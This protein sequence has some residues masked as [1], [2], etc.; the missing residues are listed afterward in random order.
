MQAPPISD[1]QPR[2]A[3]AFRRIRSIIR[4]IPREYTVN[5]FMRRMVDHTVVYSAILIASIFIVFFLARPIETAVVVVAVTS[6]GAVSIEV[7]SG[8]QVKWPQRLAHLLE[9]ALA[10]T[11]VLAAGFLTKLVQHLF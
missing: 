8:R 3:L 5:T 4:G 9:F 1:P 6:F 10:G 7:A 2:D 11:F